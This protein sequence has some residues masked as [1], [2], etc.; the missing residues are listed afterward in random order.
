MVEKIA[1]QAGDSWA[2]GTWNYGQQ[3][4]PRPHEDVC[5]NLRYAGYSTRNLAKPG[6]SN[7]ESVGRLQDYLACNQQ[8]IAH[9]KFVLFWQT[10]FFREIWYNAS[11]GLH[12]EE[13]NLGYRFVKDHW[14]YRPYHKLSKIAQR[15]NI[16]IYVIGGCSDCIWYEN[17]EADFRGVKVICQSVTNLLLTGNHR[18]E[19]PVFCE[20]MPGW[21]DRF[22]FLNK[23]KRNSSSEDLA[24]LLHDMEL[25]QERLRLFKDNPKF[26]APDGIHPNKLAHQT[27]FEYLM[28]NVPE[29]MIDQKIA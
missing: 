1:V 26:F 11:N 17:F 14:V 7:L 28:Q 9:I 25:G 27:V 5:Q 13:L 29:L 2:A 15:W 3:Q 22:D 16:P 6:G 4:I 23:V 24:T 20:F 8:E 19:E 18:I 12:R 21:I 10:E